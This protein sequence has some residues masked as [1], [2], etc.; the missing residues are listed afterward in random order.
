M[1][2]AHVLASLLLLVA[3]ACGSRSGL[4]VE[5]DEHPRDAGPT[6]EVDAGPPPCVP[7]PERCNLRD[8]D[9]DGTVDDG[10]GF[11]A[12]GDVVVLRE[13]EFDTGSCTSC[14]WAWDTIVA[15]AGTGYL[16]AWYVGIYGGR[17]M[18]NLFGRRLDAS[19]APLGPVERLG[20]EVVLSLDP[21]TEAPVPGRGR[22]VASC[23]R[24][25]T[26]DRMGWHGFRDDGSLARVTPSPAP[27]CSADRKLVYTGERVLAV[28]VEDRTLVIR[29]YDLDGGDRGETRVEVPDLLFATPFSHR[30]EVAILGLVVRG[31]VRELWFALA[32][33]RGGVLVEPF[34]LRDVPY[35]PN[36]R[37]IGVEGGW[38][39]VDPGNAFR[40]EPA[41][42]QRLGREGATETLPTPWADGRPL[43]DSGMNDLLVHHPTEPALVAVFQGPPTDEGRP[44]DIHVEL[45]DERGDP[46]HQA[47]VPAPGQGALVD[48]EVAYTNDRLTLVW[49]D[50]A[51][52]AQKN[53]VFAQQLGC[54]EP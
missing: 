54:V 23:V 51:E 41:T 30:G 25:G 24:T 19:G 43:G 13:D 46:T 50:L 8:D 33:A 29:A 2:R 31:D 1:R 37:A 18:P 6:P 16:A 36:T 47:T 27:P 35:D 15:E 32:D 49:H 52:D 3:S 9:C 22:L 4:L 20:G 11:G 42:R 12:I 48:P 39:L 5:T 44:G 53:R 34:P 7:S 21:M 14:A 10:L 28:H 26:N 40:G 38:L 17:E 45:L